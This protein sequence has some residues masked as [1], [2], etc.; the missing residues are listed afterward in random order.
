M[1]GDFL[2]TEKGRK[3]AEV[4]KTDSPIYV[5]PL[6]FAEISS[7]ANREEKDPEPFIRK[8]KEFSKS[9]DLDE[10]ILILSG[11]IHFDQRKNNG[12]ISLIDSVI[13]TSAAMHGLVLLT[14]DSD[15][16]GLAGV[17]IV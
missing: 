15:F 17:N 12:K 14:C 11:K 4:L 10:E 9:L 1:G 7:W 6:T 13:Y 8:I 5:C 16:A 3:I 2:D